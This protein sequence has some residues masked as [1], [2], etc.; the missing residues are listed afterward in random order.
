VVKIDEQIKT[1]ENKIEKLGNDPE[2]INLMKA[3]DDLRKEKKEL[4]IL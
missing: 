2:V 3:N 1:N 4:S